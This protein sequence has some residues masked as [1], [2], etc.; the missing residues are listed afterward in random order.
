GARAF[1][2]AQKVSSRAACALESEAIDSRSTPLTPHELDAR[3]D[4]SISHISRSA[5][6]IALG[7]QCGQIGGQCEPP[8]RAC[9][10]QHVC[11]ARVHADSCHLASM[12]CYAPVGLQSAKSLENVACAGEHC[13]GR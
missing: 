13:G 3:A 6:Q 7:K 12:R 2:L 8:Q 10:E 4:V 1:H 5:Q 9:S 11:E